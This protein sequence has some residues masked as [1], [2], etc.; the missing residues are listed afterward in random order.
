MAAADTA[1]MVMARVGMNLV[2]ATAQGQRGM[3]L[4]H[5]GLG[6]LCVLSALAF[7]VV[8]VCK[9]Q[10]GYRSFSAS[11]DKVGILAVL[12]S[13]AV[14]AG[15]VTFF[16][17]QLY[18]EPIGRQFSMWEMLTLVSL[19]LLLSLSWRLYGRWRVARGV[20]LGTGG[21]NLLLVGSGGSFAKIRE[22]FDGHP[23]LG[24][25][26]VE[27]L[28]AREYRYTSD[29]LQAFTDLVHSRFVD[30][31]LL[32]G[33]DDK[34]T[35][36]TLRWSERLH[37]SVRR[38]GK[39]FCHTADVAVEKI[40]SLATVA[41]RLR[42]TP[43]L[44][45]AAKRLLDLV[46]ATLGLLW[47]SPVLLL[48]ALAIRL[49][50]RGPV[51]HLGKRVGRRGQ[52]FT[53]YKFRSMVNHAEQ[54]RES[55]AGRNE[56]KGVLFK[57]SNDPRVTRVGR[58]LRKYSLDEL[59]QLWNV[60]RGEMSLVGPRPPL[61]DEYRRYAPEHCKRLRVIP[62]ITGLWQVSAREDSSFDNYIRLDSQ[63]VDTWSFRLD[64]K[65]LLRTFAC[66]V[67]GTGS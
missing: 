40:G 50:S 15:S 3:A 37:Y 44:A 8:L 12:K 54:Q 66:V 23:E 6:Q 46:I 47:I 24:Y 1:A 62:G 26:V 22:Y 11:Y 29:S 64:L 13:Y 42:K 34:L 43:L 57:I 14:A 52:L 5:V 10:D 21:R 28:A 27:V 65:L 55:L 53:F 9:L 33:A 31:V 20:K 67:R 49:D 16:L 17:V 59:P 36:E 51:L 2:W 19:A 30:E 32:I 18:F 48:I 45:Q 39:D 61:P 41:L 56:R 25:K 4:L 58:V 63:Y 7:L 38:C 60:L 35:A